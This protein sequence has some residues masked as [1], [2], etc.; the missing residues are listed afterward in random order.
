MELTPANLKYEIKDYIAYGATGVINTVINKE[1][2]TVYAVKFVNIANEDKHRRAINEQKIL[3]K[4]DHPLII[5]VEDYFKLNTTNNV[6]TCI[7]MPYY[8]NGTLFDKLKDRPMDIGLSKYYFGC[9]VLAIEYLHSCRIC[10]R[11]LKPENILIADDNRCVLSDFDLSY[12]MKPGID[13]VSGMV[14]TLEYMAPEIIR[15][16]SVYTLSIDCYALGILLYELLHGYTPFRA[17]ETVDTKMKILKNKYDIKLGNKYSNK[18]ITRLLNSN[19]VKRL[20][21]TEIKESKFFRE[22]DFKLTLSP[23]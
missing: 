8:S 11:D 6:Y 9:I 16:P 14:G 21:S 4:C 13:V 23:P 1:N 12:A 22:F 7:V 17:S 5:H 2:N 10:Y 3:S 20:T 15:Y 19:P 18:L